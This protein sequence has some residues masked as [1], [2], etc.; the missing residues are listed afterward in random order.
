MNP[1]LEPIE[2]LALQAQE[3][4]EDEATQRRLQEAKA[5]LAEIVRKNPVGSVGIALLAGFLIGKMTK[6]S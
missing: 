5:R 3:T 2:R 4:W 1:I 6:R